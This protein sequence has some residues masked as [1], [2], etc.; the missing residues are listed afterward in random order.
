MIDDIV[1]DSD[2]FILE[3]PTA[4]PGGTIVSYSMDDVNYDFTAGSG[5]GETSHV[6]VS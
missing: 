5:G 3:L 2:N 6:F 4:A 1:F